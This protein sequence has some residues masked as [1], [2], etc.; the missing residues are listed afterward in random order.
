M[1]IDERLLFYKPISIVLNFDWDILTYDQRVQLRHEYIEKQRK[2]NPNYVGWDFPEHFGSKY[3][4]GKNKESK[5]IVDFSKLIST[6]GRLISSGRKDLSVTIGYNNGKGYLAVDLK[7][8]NGFERFKAH[9]VVACTFI[10]IPKHLKSF[11]KKLVVNHKNDNKTH[12][13]KSNLE[14]VTQK[15]NILKAIGSGVKKSTYFKCIVKLPGPLFE[16]E[17]YFYQIPSLRKYGFN[18]GE[19][20]DAI[21]TGNLYLNCLW[22]KVDAEEVQNKE[23]GISNK[24]LKI[25]RD[26]SNGRSNVLA[27][28]GTI[29]SE[30]PCKNQQF[31]LYGSKELEKYGFSPS[32]IADNINKKIRFHKGCIWTRVS[33]EEGSKYPNGLTDEQKQHLFSKEKKRYLY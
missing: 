12:N 28:V 23:L 8:K 11:K 2:K 19:V 15:E 16:K 10:P 4:G 26:P 7:T 14:W 30:G 27:T 3:G 33:K 25:L 9:R 31:V 1:K 29:I 18:N 5:T 6:S 32:G 13:L 20:Y 24:D 17:Y 21:N 22:E